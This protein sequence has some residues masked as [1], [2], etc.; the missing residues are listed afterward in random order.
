MMNMINNSI[1]SYID[2]I[3]FCAFID[4]TFKLSKP[5]LP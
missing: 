2:L 5:Y 4:I 1:W 3:L